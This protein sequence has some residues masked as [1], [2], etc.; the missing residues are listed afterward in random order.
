MNENPIDYT[1]VKQ[2]NGIT[3]RV[4][5]EYHKPL[6]KTMTVSMT[7]PISVIDAVVELAESSAVSKSSMYSELLTEALEAREKTDDRHIETN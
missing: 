7:L 2:K 5:K 1:E 3:R 4:P 6:G